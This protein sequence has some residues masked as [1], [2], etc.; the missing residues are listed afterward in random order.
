MNS[1]HRDISRKPTFWTTPQ[2]L[3]SG[4]RQND[5]ASARRSDPIEN[6][7]GV[8]IFLKRLS[9]YFILPGLEINMH[10]CA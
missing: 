5:Y 1:I 9:N 4:L 7:K 2:F 6:K 8:S 3:D 10:C